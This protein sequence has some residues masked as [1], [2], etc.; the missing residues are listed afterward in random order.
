MNDLSFMRT[1]LPM[2]KVKKID[3]E[4]KEVFCFFMYVL[5]DDI[6]DVTLDDYIK[7][8]HYNYENFVL[9]DDNDWI[10]VPTYEDYVDSLTFN[11][12]NNY[13]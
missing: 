6:N 2:E 9:D 12:S 10:D 7:Q 3:L 11:Y 13:F 1:H 5:G 8:L 4:N